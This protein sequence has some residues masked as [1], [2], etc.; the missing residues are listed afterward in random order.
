MNYFSFKNKVPI[1]CL[2]IECAVG[3][4]FFVHPHTTPYHSRSGFDSRGDAQNQCAIWLDR[5][6]LLTINYE[7]L[8]VT[9]KLSRSSVK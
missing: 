3:P 6:W 1:L 8:L 9:S 4:G 2:V 7:I 5:V